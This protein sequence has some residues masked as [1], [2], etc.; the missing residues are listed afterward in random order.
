[1]WAQEAK[2]NSNREGWGVGVVSR[3]AWV[4]KG[5]CSG[6]AAEAWTTG[7]A[8]PMPP[9]WPSLT[10]VLCP[11]PH[12]PTPQPS[13]NQRAP[14]GNGPFDVTLPSPVPHDSRSLLPTLV[15]V[16]LGAVDTH[17][18]LPL[19]SQTPG[20]PACSSWPCPHGGVWRRRPSPNMGSPDAADRLCQGRASRLNKGILR[21]GAS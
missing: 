3:T 17:G 9:V 20:A 8:S 4:S 13:S 1:M 2:D 16:Q 10:P 19:L 15:C 11:D 18:H 5:L 14:P 6:Q 7:L 21:H 12:P